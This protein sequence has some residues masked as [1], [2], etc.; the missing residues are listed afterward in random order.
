MRWHKFH[1]SYFWTG[2]PLLIWTPR[3]SAWEARAIG[4]IWTPQ[5]QAKTLN[6]AK[7]RDTPIDLGLRLW[8][9]L[10]PNLEVN[11]CGPST[12]DSKPNS[13]RGDR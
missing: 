1:F 6:V 12:F 2:L 11:A 5:M 4:K 9:D 3:E 8:S 7:I 10:A 13:T